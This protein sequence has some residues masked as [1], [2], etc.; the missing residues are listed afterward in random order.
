MEES[1]Y[2]IRRINRFG[3]LEVDGF[4]KPPVLERL[5]NYPDYKMIV[6]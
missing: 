5:N 4:G 3:E 1:G 2:I 6:G